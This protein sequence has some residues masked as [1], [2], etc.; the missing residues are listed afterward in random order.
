[1]TIG[2]LDALAF[3][4][5]LGSLNVPSAA[6]AAQ[7]QQGCEI[8]V[9]PA[10]GAH[11]VGEDF[12]AIKRV[13]QDIRDY[14]LAAGRDLNW[15]SVSRQL[16]ILKDIQISETLKG[17]QRSLTLHPLPLSR[18]EALTPGPRNL[19]DGCL[20]EFMIPQILLER[21]GLSTRSLRVFGVMRQYEDGVLTKSYSGFA[22]A[23]MPGFRL[24]GPEDAQAATAIV[25]SSYRQAVDMVL[26]GSVMRA[27]SPKAK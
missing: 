15:L 8:H 10:D 16:E 1:M 27:T 19:A 17:G 3:C 13:D 7:T 6:T 5:A 24:K 4:G 14:Y 18:R 23:P 9:Y 12:D 2:W 11:S 26:T 25:E 21:G 20:V 22:A